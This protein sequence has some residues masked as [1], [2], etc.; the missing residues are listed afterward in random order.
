[1]VLPVPDMEAALAGQPIHQNFYVK[2]AVDCRAP[3]VLAGQRLAAGTQVAVK[4]NL[5]SAFFALNRSN[6]EAN[7]PCSP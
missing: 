2:L 3:N 5:G 1:M 4:K 7:Q 6:G